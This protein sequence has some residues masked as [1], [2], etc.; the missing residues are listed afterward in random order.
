ML[1]ER[2]KKVL[3]VLGCEDA[4]VSVWLCDDATIQELHDR[5]FGIDEPTN[6]ISFAQ[7]DGDFPDVE[8]E[9]LGDVV[10]SYETAARDAALVGKSVDDEVIFLLIHGILHLLGYDHEG[11]NTHKAPEMEAKEEELYKIAIG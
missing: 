3:S 5:W 6:V 2:A 7:R 1:E 4:E 10:I 8:P 9:M 11:E